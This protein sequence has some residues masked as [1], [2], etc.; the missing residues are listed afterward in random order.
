[1]IAYLVH[2]GVISNRR[3]GW[4]RITG[5]NGMRHHSNP[6]VEMGCTSLSFWVSRNKVRTALFGPSSLHIGTGGDY[7]I[8]LAVHV[9]EVRDEE[10]IGTAKKR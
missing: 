6:G 7:G 1:M 9:G 10:E 3:I 4:V 5:N 8:G 2:T